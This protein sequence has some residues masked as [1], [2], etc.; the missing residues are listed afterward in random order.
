VSDTEPPTRILIV[1]DHAMVADAFAGAFE[2]EGDLTVVGQATTIAEAERLASRTEPDLAVVDFRLPDGDGGDAIERL[3]HRCPQ[4]RALV[5]TS[6]SDRRSLT[7]AL[8]ADADGYLLKDQPVEEL[9]AGVRAVARGGAAFAPGLVARIVAMS[10]PSAS[11]AAQLSA[12][13]H[14]VLQLLALGRSTTD[15]AGELHISVNTVRNHVQQ[16][17]LR[18][19]A[20]SRIEAVAN[21]MRSGLIQPPSPDPSAPR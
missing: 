2:Q 20:H 8:A 12:R 5:V 15:I 18:L 4:I 19:D 14:E 17:L 9:L 21:G 16:V 10:R 6:A 3:R 13:E 11:G 7:R 1:E